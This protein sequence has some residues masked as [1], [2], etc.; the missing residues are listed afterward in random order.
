M[1][2][3]ELLDALSNFNPSVYPTKENLNKLVFW[4]GAPRAYPETFFCRHLLV[5]HPKSAFETF[6]WK[7]GGRI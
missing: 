7:T 4:V 1:D 5:S 3:N 6:G 2:E